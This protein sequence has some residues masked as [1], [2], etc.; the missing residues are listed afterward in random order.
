MTVEMTC[1]DCSFTGE[2]DSDSDC[3][4]CGGNLTPVALA[5]LGHAALTAS[6]NASLEEDS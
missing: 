1:W 2:I 4:E 5:K 6:S 3:P